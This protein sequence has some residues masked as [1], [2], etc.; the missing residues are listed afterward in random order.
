M[1]AFP[2]RA[3]VVNKHVLLIIAFIPFLNFVMAVQLENAKSDVISDDDDILIGLV[4]NSDFQASGQDSIVYQ[5]QN[6][7]LVVLQPSS[8]DRRQDLDE[9]QEKSL[10]FFPFMEQRSITI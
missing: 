10:Q 1:Y 9:N 4:K 5:N 7:P 8:R 3:S 2:H 6:G